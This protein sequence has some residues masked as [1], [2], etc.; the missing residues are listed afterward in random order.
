[1]TGYA[2]GLNLAFGPFL[3]VG[4]TQLTTPLKPR[5]RAALW[6]GPE[7][8][9]SSGGRTATFALLAGRLE[10]CPFVGD[11]SAELD[12][13]PCLAV[14]AGRVAASG[15]EGVAPARSRNRLWVAAWTGLSLRFRPIPTLF[16]EAAGSLGLPVTRDAFV[17]EG[18]RETVHSVPAALGQVGLGAGVYFP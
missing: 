18:P 12:V 15:K 16:L 3:E 8:E 14:D 17:L 11:L 5:V 13:A 4:A 1:M 6:L 9:V 2:P 10:G 7:S